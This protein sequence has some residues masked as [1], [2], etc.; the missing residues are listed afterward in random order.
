MGIISKRSQWL[1]LPLFI[2]VTSCAPN[3][4]GFSGGIPDSPSSPSSSLL[5]CTTN[6]GNTKIKTKMLFIV[7]MSESNQIT[8]GCSLGAGCSDP[9]KRMRSGSIEKF[10]R[11][12]GNYTNFSWGF[13]GFQGESSTSLIRGFSDREDM[14]TAI[15]TF[16]RTSDWGQTPYLAALDRAKEIISNDSDLHTTEQI[17]YLILFMSD[18]EPSDSTAE[19]LVDEVK[20]ISALAKKKITFNTVYYGPGTAPEANL[21]SDLAKTGGGHFLNT[22]TNP[23]GLDFAIKDILEI[24]CP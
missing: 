11:D 17:Q 1:V 14:A 22:N 10:F 5:G 6:L 12:Y 15:N 4:V 9:N 21:L 20:S 13:V 23:T 7:D 16:K 3:K 8:P 24:P 2:L 19:Q 18:G